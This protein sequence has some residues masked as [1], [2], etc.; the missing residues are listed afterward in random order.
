MRREKA[1]LVAL[2]QAGRLVDYWRDQ[3]FEVKAWVEKIQVPRERD[4][5]NAAGAHWV[6]RSDMVNGHPVK[7]SKAS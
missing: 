6:V 1:E 2:A 3:G 7:R 4:T 5:S